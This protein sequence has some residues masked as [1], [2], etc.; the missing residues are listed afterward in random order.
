MN[1]GRESTG[2]GQGDPLRCGVLSGDA[3]GQDQQLMH[4][5]EL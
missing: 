2:G 4:I 5:K 1:S 3:A